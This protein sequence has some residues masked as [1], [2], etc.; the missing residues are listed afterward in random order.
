MLG[1][2][3]SYRFLLDLRVSELTTLGVYLAMVQGQRTPPTRLYRL[4]I[5]PPS[6]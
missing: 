5:N 4:L 2:A 1:L 6:V 3:F